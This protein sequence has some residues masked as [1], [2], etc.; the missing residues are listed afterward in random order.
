MPQR[1]S[2]KACALTILGSGILAFGL[3]NI[4]S[5]SPITEGGI[6]GLTLLLDHW[7]SLSPALTGLIFNAACYIFGQIV[8]GG[9]FIVLSLA[10]GC[11]FSLFYWVFEQ[12]PPLFPQ[13]G[14]YPLAAALAGAVFVGVG[15]GLGVRM[16]AASGGDDALAMG[17]SKLCGVKISSVYLVSDVTVLLLSLSY[18]PFEKIAYSLLTVV[19]SGQII[20]L[21]DGKKPQRGH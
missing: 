14:Q 11:S 5:V 4:H 21:I 13:I 10:A 8:L 18:I 6:L 12:F 15:V 9:S 1:G 3:Y 16:G 17:I 19:L 20:G 2:L 7:F